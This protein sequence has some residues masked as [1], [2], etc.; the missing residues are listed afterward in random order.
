[1]QT[2]KLF[3]AGIALTCLLAGCSPAAPPPAAPDTRAADAQAVR[4]LEA[5]WLQS[6]STKDADKI[7]AFYADDASLFLSGCP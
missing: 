3:P 7:T 1:M 4:Q 5:D 6:E 2:S